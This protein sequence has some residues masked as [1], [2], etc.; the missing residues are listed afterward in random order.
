MF[1]LLNGIKFSCF[2]LDYFENE[3]GIK[4]NK[5]EPTPISLALALLREAMFALGS[6]DIFYP[7]LELGTMLLHL[8]T[9]TEDYS[10]LLRYFKVVRF[11]NICASS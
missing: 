6:R 9:R 5:S 3:I 10:D 4:I 1:K 8:T 7:K 2:I 11:Y